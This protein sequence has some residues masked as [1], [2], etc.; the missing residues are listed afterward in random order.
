MAKSSLF[1]LV[2]I[3]AGIIYA[4]ST[5]WSDGSGFKQNL[6]E[7]IDR[8][9]QKEVIATDDKLASAR[10]ES[11]SVPLLPYTYAPSDKTAY[12]KDDWNTVI[13]APSYSGSDKGEGRMSIYESDEV[14]FISYGSMKGN[15]NYGKVSFTKEKYRRS[16]DDKPISLV[17][18]K[19]FYPEQ[20]MQLHMEGTLSDRLTLYIDHDSQSEKN[21]Y[22]MN[23]KALN[24]NELVQEINAGEIDV[25]F[26]KSKYATYDNMA[27]KGL[28]VDVTLKKNNLQVQAFGSAARGENVEE[29][30]RGASSSNTATLQEYRYIPRT[31]Y[32][33]EPY[34]RYDGRMSQPNFPSAYTSLNTFTSADP[35][36]V[37]SAVNINPNDFAIYMD[38]QDA[39]NNY[40]TIQLPLDGGYYKK[41]SNGSD[42]AINFS[43]GLITFL[44]NV[45][46]NA[47]IFVV[48][49]LASASSDPAVRT[50][51][52]PGQNFVFIKYGYAMDEDP[53]RNGIYTDMN[54]DGR[55]NLDVYEVRSIFYLGRRDILSRNFS[56]KFLGNSG[57]LSSDD[58]KKLG[59]Y[60]VSYSNG[61][62]SFKL[63][64]PFKALLP[65]ALKNIIYSE[66]PPDNISDSSQF[67]IIADYY[68]ESRSFQLQHTNIL[69]GSERI[70]V[71]GRELEPSL[72]SIDYTAGYLTF[73]NPNDPQIT[74]DTIIEVSYQYQPL[75]GRSN[76]F[77]GGVRVD[78]KLNQN[79]S[80]GGSALISGSSGSN[81]IPNVNA[82]PE[83]TVL[84]EGDISLY[85]DQA[86]LAKVY[87][88][89]T[90]AN[91]KTMPFEITGYAEYARSYRNTNTFGKGL[92]DNMETSD[93]ALIISMYDK[94]WTLASM[95]NNG[96][97]S[98]RGKM[99]YWYYRDLDNPSEIKGPGFNA[100]ELPY[101]V[102]PGPYNIAMGHVAN[103]IHEQS[104]QM[105]L[106][107]D[108]DF[109]TG[110]Q[111]SATVGRLSEGSVDL[112]GLQYIEIDYR[113]DG[114]GN[115]V[116]MLID[117][118][119]INEDAD[120]DG[121]LASEDINKNG[122]M[123]LGE[124]IGYRFNGNN[125]TV[126][127]SGPGFNSTTIG[128][129]ILNT[130]DINGN[131][132]LDVSES[133]YSFPSEGL[134]TTGG[135]WM[136]KRIYVDVDNMSATNLSLL[137]QVETLRLTLER[138]SG[139]TGRLYI[140]GIR[141]VSSRWRNPQM[142]GFSTDSNRL[143]VT[144]LNTINDEEYRAE[145][146]MTQNRS[147]YESLY[148]NKG[149]EELNST[150]ETTLQLEYNIIG[151]NVS[152]ERKFPE[153]LD[154]RHYKSLSLWYNYRSTQNGV[155]M[156]VRIGSSDTDYMEFV[157]PLDRAR[158][159][160]EAKLPLQDAAAITG[161]PDMK[162]IDRMKIFIAGS[163]SVGKIWIND[164]YAS[165]SM[166]FEGSAYWY[167]GQF[168]AMEPLYR[169]E[170][171]TPV[172]SDVNISYTNRGRGSQFA[173]LGQPLLESSER[174]QQVLSSFT[175][176]PN[177]KSTFDYTFEET[178]TDSRDETVAEDLR[179]KTTRNIF[180]FTASFIP[181]EKSIPNIFFSN[182][183]E[184]FTNMLE[185]DI[186][187]ETIHN[188]TDRYIHAPTLVLDSKIEDFFSGSLT[189]LMKLDLLFAKEDISRGS[190]TASPGFVS[191][192]VSLE[193]SEK[194]Q[195]NDVTFE[196]NYTNKIFYI[197]PSIN[198]SS[199]ALVQYMGKSSTE[200]LNDFNGGFYLPFS[201]NSD[202]KLVQRDKSLDFVTGISDYGFV[203]P[204]YSMN[205]TYRENAFRDYNTSELAKSGPFDRC[206][207]A[208]SAA[209]TKID[210]PLN[211]SRF[212]DIEALSFIKSI[213]ASFS[214]SI[215]LSEDSAP[216]E[217]EG[218]SA[219]NEQYGI[220]RSL[221]GI[222]HA[223]LNLFRYYPG[224]FFTGNDTASRG[225]DY[226]HGTFNDTVSGDGLQ[227]SDY[228]N[229]LR[230]IENY[231][232]NTFF[233]FKYFTLDGGV[234]INQVCGRSNTSGVPEQI[235]TRSFNTNFDFN[236]M[237]IF[238]FWFFRPNKSGIP[239]H[240]A[241][242]DVGYFFRNNNM[243]TA[244][245]MED[246]HSITGGLS[247]KRDR[248]Y[249]RIQG[250]I[251]LRNERWHEFISEGADR[252]AR[253]D[254]Y[255]N[256]LSTNHNFKE[257]DTG[258]NFSIIF[259]TNVQWLYDFFSKYYALAAE[260]IFKSDFIIQIKTYDYSETTSPEPYD[261][262]MWTNSL[263][264]DIHKNVQGNLSSHI[265]LENFRDIGTNDI[266]SQVFSYGITF[267]FTLIF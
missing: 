145:S 161:K 88:K 231:S 122:A 44:C 239:H 72:Y 150:S 187:G 90:G 63:R 201:N 38:D 104:S 100:R 236:L 37:P 193:E 99:Y 4:A 204:R 6:F 173:S 113:L 7:Y 166:S 267:Q 126:V 264:L 248:T 218:A 259:E 184:F 108:Y 258:Y 143:K 149:N 162:R 13:V 26:N 116:N 39:Y 28:G 12:E 213:N 192:L 9:S 217:G 221:Y 11:S 117:V 156:R 53:D 36:F 115:A 49:K 178:E 111:V 216:Y 24:D 211:M 147:L 245:A 51:V 96:S 67:R 133:V 256:N 69:E 124:D 32:Q 172:F 158:L 19:G 119:K 106:V 146:F 189:G 23:Y 16:D 57:T 235:I 165:D 220:T 170:D 144:Y 225:R 135:T 17:T 102:K 121:V 14:E 263:T 153:K 40:N 139:N 185:D 105:S 159:W 136:K 118:G 209:N 48:Y 107:F 163:G 246:E 77:T 5:G 101:S 33:L 27:N 182:K 219:F 92:I 50:D 250:G 43:T 249:F 254:I 54:G 175:I 131:G 22:R 207:D 244:N 188:N 197:R 87:N 210:L 95:R 110:N 168:K 89:L 206:R 186:S 65:S 167:E 29:I 212:S 230:M 233:D 260:P 123:E 25:K 164:I 223:G 85:M 151:Q 3:S 247:L 21:T 55:M 200:I 171:G 8:N 112:S 31:Y 98:N 86:S 181:E 20:D 183:S 70:K 237:E 190:N 81:Y 61:T 226:V 228:D 202:M 203:S 120:G 157:V 129:G 238:D 79:I 52:Y 174:Y 191:S 214:R 138:S 47:R 58:I 75:G 1:Y 74:A 94:H 46:Q 78:Y 152:I 141:F 196:I 195:K 199:E 82:E 176:L 179:G 64:E 84:V 241:S 140:S 205:M 262:Y 127:G 242:F 59:E 83:Q 103:S 114:A 177:L 128:D 137:K 234:A 198:I 208:Q 222:S 253:D 80:I 154:L 97:Q 227:F 255:Y 125:P 261:L 148:G 215:F 41:L 71:N 42:Y 155:S 45:P 134:G 93:D 243:I 229:T 62:I 30:F 257:L 169:M 15:I 76:D 73:R 34:I 68:S 130:E 35:N 252:R 194:R 266:R 56:L 251:D 142:D 91:R 10:Q 160:Q 232:L 18:T 60:T 2:I 240:S 132:T 180:N 265:A 109:S 66:R 224:F